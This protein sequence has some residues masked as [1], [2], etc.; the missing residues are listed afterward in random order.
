M[1][2]PTILLNYRWL[3]NLYGWRFPPSVKRP[4]R[5]R[6]K[7]DRRHKKQIYARPSWPGERREQYENVKIN[8]VWPRSFD[9][10]NGKRNISSSIISCHATLWCSCKN[11]GSSR[12]FDWWPHNNLLDFF[13]PIHYWFHYSY[14]LQNA[15]CIRNHKKMDIRYKTFWPLFNFMLHWHNRSSINFGHS[16]NCPAIFT[17][18]S[19]DQNAAHA[20]ICRCIFLALNHICWVFIKQNVL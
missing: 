10:N 4:P 9:C 13:W 3:I 5:L 18:N 15:Y 20:H 8:R 1:R 16:Y 14:N 11:T 19:I 12:S 2:F 7:K 6:G 17:E